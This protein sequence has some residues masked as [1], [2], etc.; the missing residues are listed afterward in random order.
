MSIS[1]ISIWLIR[2]SL[3]IWFGD[4]NINMNMY[5]YINMNINMNMNIFSSNFYVK[6]MLPI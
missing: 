3:S 2:S 1:S 6:Y 4:F 5:M